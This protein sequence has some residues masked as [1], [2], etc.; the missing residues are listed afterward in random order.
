MHV[1]RWNALHPLD[2]PRTSHI[3][4]SLAGRAGPV[5]AATDYLRS[6][7]DQVRE[8]V[9]GTYRTLGT[10]GFGRS[11]YRATLRSFFEVDRRHV[12]VSALSALCE[13]GLILPAV[14]GQAISDLEIDPES[15]SPWTV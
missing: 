13:D 11:D 7:A 8:W 9:P 5:V 2:A 15:P 3:A 12:V 6:F 10:D 1:Q 4:N 14:V